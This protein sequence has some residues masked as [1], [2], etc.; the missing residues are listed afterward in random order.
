[1][2]ASADMKLNP[3]QKKMKAYTEVVEGNAFNPVFKEPKNMTIRS[4]HPESSFIII[5]VENCGIAAL[6]V[7][8]TKKGYRA[9]K[10]FNKNYEFVGS[11]VFCWIE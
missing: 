8:H 4:L 5:E 2:G 9:A 3:K 6:P 10:L 11:K 7:S 1:M